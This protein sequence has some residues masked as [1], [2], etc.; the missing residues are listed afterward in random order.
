MSYYAGDAVFFSSGTPAVVGKDNITNSIKALL[1]VPN[2]QLNIT[3]ASVDVARSG[4]LAFDRGTVQATVTGKNGKPSTQTSEYALTW[5]KA[6]DG[7]WK[8]VADTSANEK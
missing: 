6:S 3:V 1:A 7:S 2:M 5:K 8:I 4:D